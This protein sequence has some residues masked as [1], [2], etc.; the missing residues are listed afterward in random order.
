MAQP[1]VVQMAEPFGSPGQITQVEPQAVG[2]LSAEHV[3]PHAWY[4]VAQ[5]T[6]QDVPLHEAE[7]APVGTG[8]GVHE[9]PHEFTFML[10]AH[11]PPQSW[12]PLAHLPMQAWLLGTQTPLQ[13]I[14]PVGQVPPHIPSTQVALPPVGSGHAVHDEPQVAGLVSLTHVLLQA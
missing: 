13:A 12:V 10:S 3:L 1:P 7:D 4:P 8:H 11:T 9:L 14:W 5:M 2:E 6:E